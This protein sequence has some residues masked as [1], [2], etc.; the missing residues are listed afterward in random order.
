MKKFAGKIF[1][2]G[3]IFGIF[4]MLFIFAMFLVI[5]ISSPVK[6]DITKITDSYLSVKLFDSENRPLNDTN[7]HGEYVTLDQIPDITKTCFLSIEDKDFYYHNGL[8]Y[9]RMIGAMIKN[10]KNFRFVEGAST[11]SQQLIKN[12]HLTNEKTMARKINEIKLTLQLEK[13]LP[14]DKILEIYLNVIYFGDNCY[15]IQNA[16]KHYFSKSVS[17]LSID[18]SAILAGMIKSPNK[19]HP[20]KN[21]QEC[22]GRRNLVLAELFKDNKINKEELEQYSNKLTTILVSTPT[23]TLNTYEQSAILEAEKILNMP[24]KQIAI[25]G[26]KI[27]TYQNK[28]KQDSLEN[29]TDYNID[30][31]FAMISINAKNATIEA[32]VEKSNISLINIK[33]QPASAIKPILVYAPALNENII[34]PMTQIL[35]ENVSINGYE[36]KN[37]GGKEH[38]YIDVRYALSQSLN[39][40]AV[41]I[42]SYIGLQKA[43]WYL[44]EQNITFDINDNSLALALGGMTY[45]ISLKELTNCYQT[46]AN[47]GYFSEAKF[48]HYIVDKNGKVIYKHSPSRKNIYRED[49]A[50]LITD[51]LHETAKKCTAKKLNDLDFYVASKTGTSSLSSKNIDAYNIS[52]TSEDVVGCWIGNIDNSPTKIVGGGQPTSFVKEYLKEIYKQHKPKDFNM[53]SSIVEV[54]IDLQALNNEHIVY[55]ANNFLPDRYRQKGVFSRFNQPK[56]NLYDQLT[57]TPPKINAK[58]ENGLAIITFDAKYYYEYELYAVINNKD[59]LLQTLSSNN[60]FGQFFCKLDENSINRFYVVAKAKDYSTGELYYSANSNTLELFYTK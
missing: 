3:I 26:Y 8:N 23:K 4:V 7:L 50:Y 46:F 13:E 29:V 51:M 54:D 19:Y 39:I 27:F 15:G 43:K 47:N 33:R 24:E 21:Y 60:G 37:I 59:V 25:G 41:K 36:P 11:I 40:P 42:L 28:E 55:K 53:P 57:I 35:D 5:Y 2:Y 30:E 9:K 14:K 31:D 34:S 1:K 10:I 16:S 58:V 6:F 48:I 22:I 56:S 20:I 49:T 12:T 17:K 52:Y 45:G 18:E 44:N 32:Y 38:G